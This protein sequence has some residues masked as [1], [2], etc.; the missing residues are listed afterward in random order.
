MEMLR[1][2]RNVGVHPVENPESR[3]EINTNFVLSVS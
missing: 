2:G 3:S 1:V